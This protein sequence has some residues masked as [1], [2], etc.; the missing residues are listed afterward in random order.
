MIFLYILQ[1]IKAPDKFYTG[2]TKDLTSRLAQHNNFPNGSKF[3]K[4]YRPWRIVH[5]EKYTTLSEARVRENY[6]KSYNGFKEYSILKRSGT[7]T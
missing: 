5:I 4:A 1:S 6:L 2:V 3:T 7:A